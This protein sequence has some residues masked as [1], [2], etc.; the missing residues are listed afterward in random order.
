[1]NQQELIRRLD[2]RC[3]FKLHGV[4]IHVG[5]P[6]F[7]PLV[8]ICRFSGIIKFLGD[9]YI[10]VWQRNTKNVT[11]AKHYRY[12]FNTNGEITFER[13]AA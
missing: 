1:M 7:D 10:V 11:V 13:Q 6:L 12:L 3:N 5:D 2:K 8:A 9:K 4:C